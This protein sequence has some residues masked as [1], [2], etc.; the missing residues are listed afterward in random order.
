MR[1][2]TGTA[3]RPRLID[4]LGPRM[5]CALIALVVAYF[6]ASIKFK[7]SWIYG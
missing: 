5:H 2:H 6:G 7:R 3:H 4:P 1:L